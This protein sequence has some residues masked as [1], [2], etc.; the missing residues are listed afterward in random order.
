MAFLPIRLF[1]RAIVIALVAIALVP[2]PPLPAQSKGSGGGSSGGGTASGGNGSSQKGQGGQDSSGSQTNS[3][4]SSTRVEADM[5]A[6]QASDT[7]AAH[8]ASNVC[9]H[10]LVIYDAQTFASVQTYE[11][12]SGALKLFADEFTSRTARALDAGALPQALQTIVGTLSALKSST[13][14]Q[15]QP[16]NL[17]QDALIAQVAHKVSELC[18]KSEVGSSV[19]IPKILLLDDPKLNDD[20]KPF[21]DCDSV[22]KTVPKQLYCVIHLRNEAMKGKD[23]DYLDKLFQTFLGNVLGVSA[24]STVKPAKGAS[25]DQNPTTDQKKDNSG[26]PSETQP[27]QQSPQNT[28]QTPTS[29]MLASIIQGHRILSELKSPATSR[30][31]V[32]EATTAGGSYRIRHNFWVELFWTTPNPSFNGGAVVA[33]LLIDPATSSV[34]KSEVLRYMYKYGKFKKAIPVTNPSNF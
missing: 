18:A 5:V 7:I 3:T 22:K 25:L 11:A 29:P 12:Y 4:S 1:I 16:V 34:E 10:K 14:F 26:S 6:Y 13:D 24:N 27:V 28:D 33:Y 32:L 8:I 15:T 21:E 17:D 20:T 30:L 23:S 19:I 31:L 9:G 2:T